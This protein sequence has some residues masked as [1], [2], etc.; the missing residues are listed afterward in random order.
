MTRPYLAPLEPGRPLLTRVCPQCKGACGWHVRT[1]YDGVNVNCSKC[2]GSGLIEEEVM[3]VY[4]AKDKARAAAQA[5]VNE[6]RA[7]Q[8]QDMPWLESAY[9]SK[10]E[11]VAALCHKLDELRALVLSWPETQQRKLTVA[12]AQT[13]H[14]C[15]VCKR[16]LMTDGGGGFVLNYGKEYAHANCLTCPTC[17]QRKETCQNQ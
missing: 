6:N 13:L 1:G 11:T 8:L 4:E 14:V 9:L 2:N 3:T 15:R 17:G 10:A 5:Q 16:S 7:K 12:D